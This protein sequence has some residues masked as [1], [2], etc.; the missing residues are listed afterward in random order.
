MTD[1]TPTKQRTVLSTTKD[2]AEVAAFAYV[3][4]ASIT[5]LHHLAQDWKDILKEKRQAKKDQK[6]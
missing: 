5:G 3:A 2:V 6:K 4:I 1:E